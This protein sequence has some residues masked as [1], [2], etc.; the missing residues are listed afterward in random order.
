MRLRPVELFGAQA[1]GLQA[2]VDIAIESHDGLARVFRRELGR[3]GFVARHVERGEFV[4]DGHQAGDLLRRLLAQHLDQRLRLRHK[5]RL[6]VRQI[7]WQRRFVVQRF[8]R[9]EQKQHGNTAPRM[10]QA[11][12]DPA[13]VPSAGA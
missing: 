7:G 6:R 9:G 4:A 1:L 12:G 13:C 2:V 8:G 5:L 10:K 11:G 3:P